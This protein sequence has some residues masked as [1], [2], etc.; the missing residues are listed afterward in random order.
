MDSVDNVDNSICPRENADSIQANR[1]VIESLLKS[2]GFEGSPLE[3]EFMGRWLDFFPAEM[4]AYALNKS[5]LSGKKNL[6]YV[7]G[8]IDSWL[9]KGIRTLE[10]SRRET[11]YDN[12][13]KSLE[14][15]G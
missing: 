3:V 6:Y 8:I 4:I 5:V 13:I 11:R 9:E 7:E 1:S 15:F 2:A 14:P 10:E 12:Y